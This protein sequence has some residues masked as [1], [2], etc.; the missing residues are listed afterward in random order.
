MSISSISGSGGYNPY[1]AGVAAA[2]RS[3]Q[4]DPTSARAEFDKF[5]QMTPAQKMRALML[6]KLGVTEEQLKA[7]PPKE[8]AKIEQKLKDMVKEQF[9]KD[10]DGAHGKQKTGLV[11]D[12]TV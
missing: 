9:A 6:A 8:R 10:A 5:S 7:M 4:A 3:A 12:V 11:A 2:P 1:S